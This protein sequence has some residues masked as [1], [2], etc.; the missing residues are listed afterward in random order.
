[1]VYENND[2]EHEWASGDELDSE[3]D[4]LVCP[5]CDGA[6]HEDTQQCPHCGDWI[7]PVYPSSRA[8]RIGWVLAGTLA[9]V[10]ILMITIFG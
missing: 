1:M 10:L 8:R 4:L 7:T 3:D 2:D 5:S 6:V 9:I